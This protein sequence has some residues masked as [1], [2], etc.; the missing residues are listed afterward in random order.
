LKCPK[1][2]HKRKIAQ[3][4]CDLPI[5]ARGV[6]LVGGGWCWGLGW[7]GVWVV[8]VFLFFLG[9]GVFVFVFRWVYF[10]FVFVFVGLF[11]V[12]CFS[13]WVFFLCFLLVGGCASLPDL[14]ARAE[15]ASFRSNQGR[16]LY[17]GRLPFEVPEPP[18]GQPARAFPC[19]RRKVDIANSVAMRL[20]S[21]RLAQFRTWDR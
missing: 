3:D 6:C 5:F 14:P 9:L 15:L 4:Y 17:F 13:F 7:V 1:F 2:V 12:C 19:C 21:L 18:I 11:F 20:Y 10:W 16:G 8:G